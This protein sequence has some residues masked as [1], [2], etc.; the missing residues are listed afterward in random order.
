MSLGKFKSKYNEV[1]H[2]VSTCHLTKMKQ[3]NKQTITSVGGEN[4]E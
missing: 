3:N 1:S 2:P 4:M